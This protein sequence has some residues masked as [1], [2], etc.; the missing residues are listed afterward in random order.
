MHLKKMRLAF[1]RKFTHFLNVIQKESEV[2][3]IDIGIALQMV[4]VTN[5]PVFT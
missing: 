2:M 5:D 4:Q 3:F 1:C